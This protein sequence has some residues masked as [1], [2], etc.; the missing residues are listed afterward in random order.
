MP[1]VTTLNG[2]SAANSLTGTANQDLIN[3]L[4]GNDTI[5]GGD[6]SDRIVG[7]T[8]ADL[9]WGGAT[10]GTPV[11]N[12]SDTY[13]WAKGDGNDEIRDWDQSLLETD[14]LEL[15]NVTSAEVTLTAVGT[16]LRVTI[17]PTGEVI[18]IDERYQNA[19]F[20]YGLERIRFS[21][22]VT[23]NLDEIL[24]QARVTGDAAA[25]T[26]TGTGYSDNLFGLAGNDTLV[27]GQGNDRLV[28][29]LGADV[30]WGDANG[31]ASAT[32]GGDTYVWA[33]G[34]GND[35]INDWGQSLTEIDTLE[36]T[37]VVSTDVALSFSNAAGADLLVTVVSTGEVIRIDERYQNATL[38]YGIERIRFSDGVSWS[39]DEILARAK[40][41]GDANANTLTGTAYRDNLVS[42]AG[43]DTLTGAAGDDYL[44][45][46]QGNDVLF[47]GFN[48]STTANNPL[49]NGVDTYFWSKGDGNDTINDWSWSTT[50]Q[51]TLVLT[52][53]LSSEVVLRRANNSF[54]LQVSI[55]GSPAP[56][57]INVNS[58][59]YDVPYGY[60]IE[61]IAFADGVLWTMQ[62]IQSRTRV[63]GT[64]AGESLS[65]VNYRD[66]L[67]GLAG[68]DTLTGNDGDDV[69]IGGVGVDSLAGGNGSD[70]YE[71]TRGDG[72]DTINDAGTATGEVDTLVLTDVA[73]TGAV[74]ARAGANLTVT[75]PQSGEVITVLNRFATAGGAAGIEAVQ[76]SD[77]VVTRVLQNQVA[78]FATTGTTAGE[79]LTG[80]AYSDSLSGLAGNDTLTGGLGDD[81]LIGGLGAD[82]LWGDA[83]GAATAT[84]GSDTYVWT[85]GDG[86]DTINDWGQS[87]TEI[88][89]LELTNVTS[90]DVVLSYSNSAG[91]DLL[92]R[93]IST[94]EILRIDERYQNAAFGY[95]IERIVFA[96]GVIWG[97]EDIL[98]R[99]Q[100]T[101]T[102]AAE[103]MTGTAR[104]DNMSGLDGND[105]LNAGDGDDVLIGGNGA[106]A[107][108]GGNGT[109]R[110]EWTKGHG[111]DT[112]TDTGAS[113]TEVDTLVLT[114]V[115]TAD[116][117]RMNRQTGTTDLTI[118][119]ES[120]N[121]TI[122]VAGQYT[123]ATAGNGIE[124]I[125]F[126]DGLVW[127]LDGILDRVRVSGGSTNDNI[128]GTAFDDNMWGFLGNDT[129]TGGAGDDTM[130]GGEGNDQLDG[131]V[132]NDR[133]EVLLVDGNESISDTGTSIYEI[134]TLRI[135]TV[136]PS[137]VD[138]YRLS[139]SND[140]RIEV[141][142]GAGTIQ[143]HIVRNQFADPTSGVGIEAIEFANGT[144]W[145]RAN[146]LAYTGTYGS[147][148]N[149]NNFVGSAS[150]D[151]MF[152]RGGDDTLTGGDGDDYLIG[153]TGIDSIYG[154][155]GM[156]QTSY[157]ADSTQ[158]VLVDLRVTTAQVGVAGGIE[159]GDILQSIEWLEGSQFDDT[160]HGDNQSNW[161][162][163]REG[164]DLLYGYDG[165]DQIRGGS[166]WDTIY[167]GDGADDIRGD[168]NSDALYGGAGGDTIEGGSFHDTIF[169]GTGDD[170]IIAGTGLDVIWGEQGADTF[171]FVD[172]LFETDTIMD[173]QDGIDRLW[174]AP[175]A[176][177]SM[178]NLTITGN[179]TTSVT[180]AV[181]AAS[182]VLN[183]ATVINLTADDF[184]FA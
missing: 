172:Q 138:L 111:N 147:G 136:A 9:L 18:L 46:G 94:G 183:S 118:L 80:T 16:D 87:Q 165:Y 14:T 91:A 29:G 35:T 81:R 125:V 22:G 153:G 96:D 181:A 184:L 102:A 171:H 107:L 160:L 10:T 149:N 101:G 50:E 69:L 124:R 156:D 58:R 62:D 106:D 133:Y 163:G 150:N 3:G 103:T 97:L 78:L 26:L 74:L 144:I 4:E 110:Y 57:T 37:D 59:F 112:I 128:V 60:G 174:F 168:H 88:D 2:T 122:R 75:V 8:G 38:G 121:E 31:A 25:N 24:R 109:D 48:Q 27:G 11:S 33:K 139:G 108:A 32:S 82:I 40:F 166:G 134:D 5:A 151:R 66:N 67:Y 169:G 162:I 34:D 113:L 73:S 154:G 6:G 180:I 175:V 84:S 76:F 56:E 49:P 92:V 13:V 51:D 95:G 19:G 132:G 142:N 173:Y 63:E 89:T 100:F 129:L 179:G 86:N 61:Q 130:L 116:G 157:Y 1:V 64:A 123:G 85:K 135:S 131:G 47:G 127:Q 23:W 148:S 28:G 152:G 36:L 161:L 43:N 98:Q 17:V 126:A 42:L 141:S 65:G 145:T 177:E 15:T 155:N 77:G 146:I 143:T 20:G 53:V 119:I 90:N 114:N 39:L 54:D 182:V 115:T 105:V 159:V 71:W 83:N 41:T 99:A 30:L 120:T 45:G 170:F 21:D 68:N 55:L 137:A 117:I 52:N 158:G 44:T 104:T 178:A 72:N 164:A 7:G 12:G 70:I 79:A 93:V 140:L 167:G 176:A